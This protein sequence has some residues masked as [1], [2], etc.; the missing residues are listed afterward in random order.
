MRKKSILIAMCAMM[1]A[2]LSFAGCNKKPP[3][4][5]EPQEGV[6]YQTEA[7]EFWLGFGKAYITFEYVT[8][9]EIPE[10]GKTY[11][12]V[13]NVFVSALGDP[14]SSWLTGTWKLE[15]GKLT[16]NATWGDEDN[17]TK[18]ADAVSGEDK[19]YEDES[20]V[21]EIGI[22]MPSAGTITFTFDP[23]VDAVESSAEAE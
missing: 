8:E 12:Y 9:P 20:Q 7:Q 19:V 4:E 14:Y 11:G 6:L 3:A 5:P 18:L 21:F 15:N 2:V 10:E 23:E 17:A 1:I 16:L 13:F 22:E